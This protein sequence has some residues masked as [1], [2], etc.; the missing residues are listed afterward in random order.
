[1]TQAELDRMMCGEHHWAVSPGELIVGFEVHEQIWE[2]NPTPTGWDNV[3]ETRVIGSFANS[4]DAER[5]EAGL[6]KQATPNRQYYIA[7]ITVR[8]PSESAQAAL[9]AIA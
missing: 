6:I 9:M 1:M 5:C 8:A 2:G 7:P 3:K 4:A